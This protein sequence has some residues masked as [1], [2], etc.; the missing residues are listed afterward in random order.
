M[1]RKIL[2]VLLAG[3]GGYFAYKKTQQ[4]RADKDL[5]SEAVDSVT[6]GH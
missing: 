1:L 3:I 4:S 5:W 6:P 2:L